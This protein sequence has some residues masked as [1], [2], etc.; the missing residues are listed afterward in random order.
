MYPGVC[1]VSWGNMVQ[2]CVLTRYTACVSNESA[3]RRTFHLSHYKRRYSS[4]T[5]IVLCVTPG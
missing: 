4:P 2:D 5:F 1:Y 3:R